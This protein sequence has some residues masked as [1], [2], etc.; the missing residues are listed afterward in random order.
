MSRRFRLAILSDV[1]YAGPREQAEGDDYEYRVLANPLLRFAIR[2][3][4]HHIW[5][6]YPL[7]QNGQLDRFLA[8][9]PGVDYAIAN[10]DYSCNTAAFGLCDDAA[11]ES[12]QECVGKLR[13]KF[14]ARLRLNFGDHE[15]GKLRLM[16]TRGGLRWKSW[17]RSVAELGVSPFWK[18]ELGNYVLFNCAST[19]VAL[20]VFAADMLP[21]ER[22]TWEKMRADHLAELRAAFAAVQPGQRILFFCH[23]PTALPFLG[24]DEVIRARLGQIDRTVIGHLHSNFYLRLSRLLSGIPTIGFCGHTV[25]R[26]SGALREARAWKPFRVLLCPSL[27]G[28][29]LLKDGGFYTVE[30][31]ADAARPAEFRFH[32]LPRQ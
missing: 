25:R 20:P 22:A 8:E 7:R 1:H 32:P 2:Q 14:G 17:E 13:Q 27:A 26:L 28:I 12:A 23:D 29:E 4:R 24:R 19:L 5:L 21:E 11:M 18:L 31:E 3:Y 10:G 16:G 6:R 9:V 30:L 15:L